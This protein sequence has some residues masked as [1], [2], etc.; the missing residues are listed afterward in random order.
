[1]NIYE[2]F[3]SFQGEGIKTGLPTTF[4]RLAGCNLNC[5]WCDTEFARDVEGSRKMPLKKIVDEVEKLKAKNVCIT[6][7]EPL[8]Q[9]ETTDL[10]K[11][12]DKKGYQVDLETNG[13]IPLKDILKEVPN[14]FLSVDVKTP[15]SGEERRFHVENLD[16]MRPTD[17]IK[18]VIKDEIDIRFAVDFLNR[19]RPYLNIIMTPCDN[20]NKEKIAGI[21][22]MELFR[23]SASGETELNRIAE[24]TRLM[25]QTHKV[26]WGDKKGV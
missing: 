23:L 24:R 9:N 14:I 3:R 4:V 19:K 26:I 22:D 16:H 10:A 1:M 21:L 2:I 18:F 13:S 5:N 7:G 15:S 8:I 12:L 6:G 25:L 11:L 20:R 17:Q